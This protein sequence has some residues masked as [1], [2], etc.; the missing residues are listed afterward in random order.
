VLDLAFACYESSCT[1]SVVI[2]IFPRFA[3][4]EY[5]MLYI[6]CQLCQVTIVTP[7][8]RLSD[9]HI[10]RSLFSHKFLPGN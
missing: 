1:T 4:D 10:F 3:G 2:A 8:N 9:Y 5:E 6:G 7:S